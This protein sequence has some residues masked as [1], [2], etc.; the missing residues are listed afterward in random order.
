MIDSFRMNM[1]CTSTDSF[2]WVGFMKIYLV[3]RLHGE[4]SGLIAVRSGVVV[5]VELIVGF[6]EPFIR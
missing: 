2:I 5:I 3:L 6:Q 4:G 1:A